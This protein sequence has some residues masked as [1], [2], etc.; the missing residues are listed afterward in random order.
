MMRSTLTGLAL[1]S[2]GSLLAA[3]GDPPPLYGDSSAVNAAQKKTSTPD[4]AQAPYPP[5]PY[6]NQANDVL[7][8]LKGGG[9]RLSPAQTDSSQLKWDDNI[10]L[11]DF[12]AN[13][14][15]KCMLV[16]FGASWCGACQQEQAA[17]PG[18][19][20]NDPSFGVL[21]ILIE[22]PVN[23]SNKVATTDVDDWTQ[24]F[25]Q[26]Y[27]VIYGGDTSGGSRSDLK[28]LWNGWDMGG[29]IGLPFNIV[30]RTTDMQVA[31]VIQG[32]SPTIHDDAMAKCAA[33]P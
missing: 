6:G 18:D 29:S 16:S 20:A 21:N 10:T 31:D 8:N 32:F 4:M 2:L 22:G 12:H 23:G 13:P 7:A 9:Y 1:L 24:M 17:L 5:P 25:H 26:N 27:P 14:K 11:E 28:A 33:I 19:I 15:L 3:C 30:V